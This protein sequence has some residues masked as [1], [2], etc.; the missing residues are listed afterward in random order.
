MVRR[1]PDHSQ[2]AEDVVPART[3]SFSEARRQLAGAQKSGSGAPPYSRWINR[4]A[5][6]ILAAAAYRLGLTPNQVTLLSALATF[7]ALTVVALARPAGWVGVLAGGLLILGYALDS[8]DGQ[9]ARLTGLGSPAGE[10]LDH[11]VDAMKTCLLHAAVLISLLRFGP[12][13][14][15][16]LLIPLGYQFVACVFFFSFILV[17]KLRLAAGSRSERIST[18]PGRLQTVLALPTD[19]GLLCLVFLVFGARTLF[20]VLYGLLFA[21]HAVVLLGALVKWW[22]ELVRLATNGPGASPGAPTE[23]E[24]ERS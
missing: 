19:Y 7:T 18:G 2:R 8:A 15:A 11:V 21:G 24:A 5:G 1:A 9:L 13:Q 3:G 17:G 10:W 14:F 22:R 4:P 6:R 20:L 16:L 23:A 12:G